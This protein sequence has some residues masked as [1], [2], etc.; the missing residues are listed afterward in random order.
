[1]PFV[2]QSDI[3]GLC[4]H[5]VIEIVLIEVLISRVGGLAYAISTASVWSSVAVE[6]G[7]VYEL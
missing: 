2:I 7:R 1:M 3:R 5:S 4:V 6:M